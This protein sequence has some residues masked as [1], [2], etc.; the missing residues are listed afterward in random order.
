MTPSGNLCIKLTF[1]LLPIETAGLDGTNRRVF[2]P[3]VG[4]ANGLTIDLSTRR[5]Y[6]TDLDKQQIAYATLDAQG[7]VRPVVTTASNRYVKF[8][9]SKFYH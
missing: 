8:F 7:Y 2:V 4:R 5:L 3:D 9:S 6:W 1:F